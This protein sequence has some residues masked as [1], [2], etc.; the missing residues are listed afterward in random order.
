MGGK[1]KC[2]LFKMEHKL[3]ERDVIFVFDEYSKQSACCIVTEEEKN[4]YSDQIFHSSQC[5]IVY[6]DLTECERIMKKSAE[7]P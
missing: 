3:E 1:K 7:N 5:T 4:L 6:P 2:V